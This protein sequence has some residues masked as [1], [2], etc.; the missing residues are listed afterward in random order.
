MKQVS[1]KVVA[2]YVLLGLI[3]SISLFPLFWMVSTSLKETYILFKYPPEFIPSSP[4]IQNY[5]TLFKNS[6]FLLWLKNSSIVTGGVLVIS[7]VISSLAG[8]AFA[9]IVF[10]GRNVLFVFILSTLMVPWFI[11]IVPMFIMFARMHL[12][13]TYWALILPIVA[14]PFGIF[15]MRQYVQTI[16]DE[17]LESAKMDGC[18]HFGIYLKII[19]P[20]CKPALATLAIFSFLGSWN[21]FFWP[22]VLIT[23]KGMRTLPLGLALFQGQYVTAWGLVMACAFMTFLPALIIFLSLQKYFVQ[24]I[25]LTGLKG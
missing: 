21:N 5:I 1:L 16:P 3:G 24:G 8:Y 14:S 4:T 2:V 13:N 10:P 9:K 25:A 18:S 23:T 7:L 20:L 12:V 22:L 19:L 6:D 15:L 17:L 11:L